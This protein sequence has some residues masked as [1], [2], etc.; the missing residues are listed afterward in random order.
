MP[1]YRILP[2]Q[3]VLSEK[4]VVYRCEVSTSKEPKKIYMGITIDF[5]T[6]YQEHK[7]SFKNLSMKN[8]TALAR[9]TSILKER[10]KQF[11][12]DLLIIIRTT[13]YNTH[14]LEWV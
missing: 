12:L 9:L 10:N 6:R 7:N 2:I 3:R 4:N 8:L 11:K 14:T 1:I 5:K 13:P